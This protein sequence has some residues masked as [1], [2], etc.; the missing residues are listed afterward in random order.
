MALTKSLKLT[1]NFGDEVYFNNP[2][3]KI[4]SLTG[5]KNQILIEVVIY[6]EVNQQSVDRKYYPFTPSL[7]GKN[8][9]AQG[10]MYLK[11][12]P[13]FENAIDC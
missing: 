10:Y 3:I 6:K 1:S 9:I 4:E 13:Q 12:L 8:F 11:T 5:N 2:Y 7:D